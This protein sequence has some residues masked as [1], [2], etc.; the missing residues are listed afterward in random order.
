MRQIGGSH[1]RRD[2]FDQVLLDATIRPLPL[3]HEAA[4]AAERLGRLG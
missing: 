4:P 3:T 1:A 2:L